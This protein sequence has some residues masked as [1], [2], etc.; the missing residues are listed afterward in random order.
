LIKPAAITI[1]IAASSFA[2]VIDKVHGNNN[3]SIKFVVA[4]DK[5]HSHKAV[6]TTSSSL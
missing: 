6:A 3:G 5:A 1:A 2:T 4:I